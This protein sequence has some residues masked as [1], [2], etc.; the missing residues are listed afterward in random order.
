MVWIKLLW[1]KRRLW[2][3]T[4]EWNM[5]PEGTLVLMV[6]MSCWYILK[7]N[8]VLMTWTMWLNRNWWHKNWLMVF[9]HNLFYVMFMLLLLRWLYHFGTNFFSGILHNV[10]NTAFTISQVFDDGFP[11][12]LVNLNGFC[13]LIHWLVGFL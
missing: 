8:N 13:S 12:V 9:L 5:I 10:N 11:E 2:R 6:L 1:R 3:V 4:N 7:F